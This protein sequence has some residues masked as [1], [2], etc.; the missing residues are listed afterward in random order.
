VSSPRRVGVN[1]L[2][3]VP[4]VVGGSE[5]YATRLLH[6]V[7]SA[8][9]D[10]IEVVLYALDPF[11]RAH[12]E[13][14]EAFETH[15]LR[16]DGRLKPLRVA[17]E[18]SWLA[19]QSKRH[20]LALVHHVGGRIPLLSPV[21]SVVTI[22]DLQPLEHPENFPRTKRMFLARA[23]PRTASRARLV[24]TPSD[25]VRRHVVERL[26]VPVER[27]IAV[28]APVEPRMTP[29]SPTGALPAELASLIDAAEPFFLY[30]VI[31][32]RHKNH[33]VLLDAFTRLH[34]EHPEVRLVLTGG[35]GDAEDDVRAAISRLQL[36]KMVIRTA[37]VERPVLDAL[38]D[39]ATA[40]VF[41]SRFEGFGLAVIEALAAGRPVIAANATAL[42]EVVGD[43]GVLVDVDDV[44]GWCD[45][46]AAQL[47][48]PRDQGA[49]A[50]R[51]RAADFAP[52]VCATR[53]L[54]AYRAALA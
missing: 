24:M 35:A 37:R 46:M 25:Y 23:L 1:L 12:P 47:R 54:D 5:E 32:Y 21:R 10:D 4:G 6:A 33:L 29:P 52:A 38:I 13:L 40:V 43:A 27:T 31:T 50:R 19:R 51:A 34:A 30:P 7:A 53:L 36:E 44:S 8:K 42:P 26:G 16:L 3:L 9:P 15:T 48:V 14:R 17:A 45:A 39:H 18:S 49:A 22:H 20:N 2:W 41:P 28:P 11:G